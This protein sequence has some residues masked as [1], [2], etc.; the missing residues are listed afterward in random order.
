MK[1]GDWQETMKAERAFWIEW[2]DRF[3]EEGRTETRS[4]DWDYTVNII[5]ESLRCLGAYPTDDSKVLEIGGGLVDRIRWLDKGKLYAIDP[6]WDFFEQHRPNLGLAWEALRHDVTLIANKAEEL[7]LDSGPFDIVFML[8]T[9]DHCEDP[10]EILRRLC[11]TMKKG[12]LLY[13]STAVWSR[14]YVESKGIGPDNLGKSHPRMFVNDD[15]HEIFSGFGFG[16]VENPLG[17]KDLDE[18]WTRNWTGK[19]WPT[20][21]RVWRKL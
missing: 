8:N 14:E 13:E 19:E 9:L 6:L 11:V 1:I 2:I 12:A 15:L 3:F 21:P 4:L 17:D 7:P 10:G 16:L 20:H 18:E 5:I